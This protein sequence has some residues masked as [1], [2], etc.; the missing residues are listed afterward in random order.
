MNTINVFLFL[1][2]HDDLN[3]SNSYIV[4]MTT[5]TTN[6]RMY[7][8]R[9]FHATRFPCLTVFFMKNQNFHERSW[10]SIGKSWFSMQNHDYSI[11]TYNVS[12]KNSI[13]F[14]DKKHFSMK[15]IY[16]SL[17]NV[18]FL[19]AHNNCSMKTHGFSLTSHDLSMEIVI[20]MNN[21]IKHKKLVAWKHSCLYIRKTTTTTNRNISMKIDSNTNTIIMI[22]TTTITT[23]ADIRILLHSAT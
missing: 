23:T 16:F 21:T 9:C 10:F 2:S 14:S 13:C 12:M 22:L 4:T 3:N 11:K 17:N 7:S 20:F 8:Q 15:H 5:T 6:T 19:I 18:W 1:N